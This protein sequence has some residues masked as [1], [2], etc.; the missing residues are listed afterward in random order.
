M[1]RGITIKVLS[2]FP[3]LFFTTGIRAL[4]SM[5]PTVPKVN[6]RVEELEDAMGNMEARLTEM[7]SQAVEK[8]LGALKHSLVDMM[9]A[10]QK[11]NAKKHG[12]DLEALGTRLEGRISRT[13]EQQEC[14]IYSVKESQEKFQMEVRSTLSSLHSMQPQSSDKMERSVNNEGKI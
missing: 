6:Q 3:S 12:A 14:L 7:V 1:H 2:S 9:L 11:E 5:A 4:R 13:R 8:G 10:S